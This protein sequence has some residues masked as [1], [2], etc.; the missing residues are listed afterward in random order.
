[1]SRLNTEGLQTLCGGPFS[2]SVEEGEC[3]ALSGPS[4]CGKTLF[5]R[6]LAD[7]DP[8]EGTVRLAG[9]NRNDMPAHYWRRRVGW[10]PAES[11]WWYSVVG[12]HFNEQSVAAN[13]VLGQLGFDPDVLGWKTERLSTGEK[14]RLALFRLLLNEPETLLLDEPTAA[15]DATNV[16]RVE[17]V[18]DSYRRATGSAVLWVSH[19]AEQ[20]SRTADRHF[21]F[22]GDGLEPVNE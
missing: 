11:V 13:D 16:Q 6:A 20:I 7:L 5:L 10:L 2:L 8:A 17:K 4:G 22:Q 15:L 12:L 19:D 9:E 14:Q 21:R 18:I 1:M 3:V